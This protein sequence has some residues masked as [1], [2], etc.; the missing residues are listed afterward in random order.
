MG[1]IVGAAHGRDRFQ[2]LGHRLFQAQMDLSRPCLQQSLFSGSR[3][4]WLANTRAKG[5]W[6]AP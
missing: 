1:L 6:A 5:V 4:L 3:H 2:A